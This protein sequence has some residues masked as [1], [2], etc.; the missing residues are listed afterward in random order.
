ME[1]AQRA[2]QLARQTESPEDLGGAFRVLGLVA[3][4]SG[5]APGEDGK[6]LDAATCFAESAKAYEAAGAEAERVRT[7]REWG[8]HE[9]QSRDHGRGLELLRDALGAFES[10]GLPFE[11][12]R[13]RRLLPH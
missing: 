4:A 11:V 3:A 13:T 9:L 10:L 6:P 2:L 7:L 12:E 5:P 1:L 8:L